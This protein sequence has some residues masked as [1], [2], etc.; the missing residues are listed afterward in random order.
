MADSP[1]F[2]TTKQLADLL[3]RLYGDVDDQEAQKPLRYVIYA[4]KSTEDEEKQTRSLGDQLSECMEYVERQ[5]LTLGRPTHIQEA[6]SAKASDK[7]PGF[8]TMLDAI[9]KGQY[10]GII[11][12]HPDRLARNMKDA[13][14]IIDLLDRGIIKDL[15]FVS[16]NFENTP[17]GLMHLGITF[18]LS[19]QCSDQ[20]S[21][22]VTR[23]IAHSV[24]DGFHINRPK[25]G[26][27]KDGA[28]RLR[29][30]GRNHELIKNAFQLR[31]ESKTF[32][33]IAKYLNSQHYE[34]AYIDGTHRTFKW[35]KQSV[36]KVLRDPVYAGV[37]EYGN[38]HIADL[39]ELYDF[40]PTVSVE[41]FEKVNNL[42]GGRNE[43]VKLAR[44]YRKGESV[45]ADLLRGMVVCSAC[46]ESR[47]TG[48]T[49]KQKKDGVERYFLYRCGT[50]GC[51]LHNKSTRA[52]VVIDYVNTFLAKKPF[53]TKAAYDHYTAEMRRVEAERGKERRSLLATLQG[54]EK[55]L[56][57]K[58][59]RIKEFI[60]DTTNKEFIENFKGD[61]L[62]A[63]AEH[64][65]VQAEIA[66]LQIIIVAEKSAVLLMPEFLELMEKIAHIIASTKNMAELDFCIKKMFSNFVVDRKNVVSA[67][68]CEPFARLADPK[69]TLGAR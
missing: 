59:E 3:K 49:T 12:W 51:K 34:R 46:G 42:K 17:S 63:E 55:A 60:L 31:L 36:Q 2:N 8:R 1:A 19:K 64:K 47:S 21:V 62:K 54:K 50:Y 14:E 44:N 40:I 45:K 23:G 7:R 30:D 24:E 16:F 28:Q 9:Q 25:H 29:P 10:D 27:F 32:E 22:N 33:Q 35:Q 37:V 38:G 26:Y 11:A 69:V 41:D 66:K 52:K 68:L 53:S 65:Q 6:V 58:Q 20:L 5:N 43:L 18:V 13:G 39:T 61:L 48:I 15:R 4:R 57:K 67:T 56:A